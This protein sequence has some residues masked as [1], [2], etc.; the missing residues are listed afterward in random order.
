MDLI[1]LHVC[2]YQ[3]TATANRAYF[4]FLGNAFPCPDGG[5]VFGGDGFFMPR[6]KYSPVSLRFQFTDIL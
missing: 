1:D 2:H 5:L 6:R 3:R 4:S